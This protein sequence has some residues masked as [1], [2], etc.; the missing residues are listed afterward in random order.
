MFGGTAAEIIASGSSPAV[1]PAP[2]VQEFSSTGSGRVNFNAGQ[3]TCQ[4][5]G[6]TCY[7]GDTC[8]CVT[9]T[10]NVTD[11]AGPLFQGPF[12]F[13]LS[14]DTLPLA[15]Q[16]NDG[17]NAGKKCFF[18][19]GVLSEIP[20]SDATINFITSGAGCNGIDNASGIYS[21]G[22]VIGPSTGGFSNA[23]GSG[24]LGFGSNFSSKI[25][26]FDLKGAAS[27]IN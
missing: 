16:Y 24:I 13:Y 27:H 5:V 11:G 15:R 26:L 9:L 18:A 20:S 3:S 14:V 17:N 21:G 7:A 25:G 10:G 23:I 6:L 4:A 1:S 2:A 22:F 8:Q 19:T 12:V